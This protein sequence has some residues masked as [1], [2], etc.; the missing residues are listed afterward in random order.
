MG[1]PTTS[2]ISRDGFPQKAVALQRDGSI[3]SELH[4]FYQTI[5]KCRKTFIGRA[6]LFAGAVGKVKLRTAQRGQFA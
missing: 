6:E 4:A 3:S 2:G 5:G 1:P